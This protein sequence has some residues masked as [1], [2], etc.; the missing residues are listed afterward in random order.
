MAVVL[1][2]F[3]PKNRKRRRLTETDYPPIYI[4]VQPYEEGNFL[5]HHE[6]SVTIDFPLEVFCFLPWVNV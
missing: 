6:M 3:F 4:Q 2:H 1:K 5:H